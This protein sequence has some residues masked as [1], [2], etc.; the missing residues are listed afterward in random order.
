[1]KTK[2]LRSLD[3]E[4]AAHEKFQG[5][6]ADCGKPVY[7]NDPCWTQY[8]GNPDNLILPLHEECAKKRGRYYKSQ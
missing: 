4:W 3:D 5:A 7:S 6:C 1:M 2:N 8:P